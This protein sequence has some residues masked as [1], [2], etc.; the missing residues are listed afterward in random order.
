MNDDELL[1]RLAAA[2]ERTD[3]PPDRLRGAA[4][5][6][7]TWDTGIAEL[8]LVAVGAQAGQPDLRGG[9]VEDL[10]FADDDRTIDLTIEREDA[11]GAIRVFGAVDPVAV[12]LTALEPTGSVHSIELD[13]AGRFEFDA[14]SWGPFAL[15]VKD[16]AGTWRTPIIDPG[17]IAPEPDGDAR[18]SE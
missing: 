2:M 9:D 5:R 3:P 12:E 15:T 16:A 18:N 17:D 1:A 11:G 13:D 8:S 14:S 10:S 4:L 6:A 7:M